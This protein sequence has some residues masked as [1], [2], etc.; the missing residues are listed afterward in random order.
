MAN[1]NADLNQVNS[2]SF[3]R[4]DVLGGSDGNQYVVKD[5]LDEGSG[6]PRLVVG[7]LSADERVKPEYLDGRIQVQ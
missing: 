1:G 3:S 2:P 4:G 7:Q 5:V 6:N